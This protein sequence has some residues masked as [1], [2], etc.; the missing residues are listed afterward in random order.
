M[1]YLT[2][3][4][5]VLNFIGFCSVLLFYPFLKFGLTLHRY[6]PITAPSKMAT[7]RP[8]DVDRG[9]GTVQVTSQFHLADSGNES[10]S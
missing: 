3:L 5:F 8:I 2:L 10:V 7:Q 6:L 9:D 4:C 1:Y